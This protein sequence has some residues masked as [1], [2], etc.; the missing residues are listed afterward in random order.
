MGALLLARCEVDRCAPN[1]DAS[2][3]R[4]VCGGAYLSDGWKFVAVLLADFERDIEVA[5]HRLCSITQPPT[6]S[7]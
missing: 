4:V 2:R 5:L 3:E 6:D 1:G 7:F